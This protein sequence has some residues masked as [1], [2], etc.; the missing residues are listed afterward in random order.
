[1][2][3]RVDV[4]VFVDA[5]KRTTSVLTT[6]AM[7]AVEPSDTA[8]VTIPPCALLVQGAIQGIFHP[9]KGTEIADLRGVLGLELLS[10]TPAVG[11][12]VTE[13]EQAGKLRRRLKRAMRPPSDDDAPTLRAAA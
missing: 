9:V 1:M 13:L 10:N 7:V 2:K 4:S 8:R 5:L 3:W 11:D 12:V 6:S